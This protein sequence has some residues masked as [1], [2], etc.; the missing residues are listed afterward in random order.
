MDNRHTENKIYDENSS[1]WREPIFQSLSPENND[2][3]SPSFHVSGS[4][5]PVEKPARQRKRSGAFPT[6]LLCVLLCAICSTFSAFLVVR[7]Y[8]YDIRQNHVVVVNGGEDSQLPVTTKMLPSGEDAEDAAL[9]ATDIYSLALSQVVGVNLT[10]TAN[11]FGQSTE[12]VVT[13]S[14]FV[15]NVEGKYYI[16]T[17]YHIVEYSVL[18]GYDI[19]VVTG[20]GISYTATLVGGDETADIA[21]LHVNAAELVPVALGDSDSIAVGETVYAVGNPLGELTNTMTSGIVSALN[22]EIRTSENQTINMF[23]MDAAVNTGNSGGPVYNKKG[24]VVGL[25]TAKY[26]NSGVEGLG[27]AIPINDVLDIATQLIS[28]GYVS[29][30][31]YLGVAAGDVSLM[32]SHY[33]GIPQGAY[34]SEV[35]PGSCAELAGICRGDVIT[36]INEEEIRSAGDLTRVLGRCSAGDSAEITLY[37][38]GSFLT[39]SLSFDEKI[40]GSGAGAYSAF[41]N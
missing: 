32:A 2:Y 15:V 41:T 6:V 34:I 1:L 28:K 11:V 19:S 16:L 3:Y 26:K 24:E 8:T 7:N 31:A 22:R 33:Y 27:F 4:Y 21:V 36:A 5:Q 9:S 17:N 35:D 37:R 30:R 25:V 40:G 38:S 13:G 20:S 10:A 29:G 12:N 18:Y 39:V 14:G 23:Q